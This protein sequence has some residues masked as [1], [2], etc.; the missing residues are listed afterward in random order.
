MLV[1]IKLLKLGFLTKSEPFFK[2]FVIEGTLMIF[3]CFVYFPTLPS[4]LQ[5]RDLFL[6]DRQLRQFRIQRKKK[7]EN[8]IFCRSLFPLPTFYKDSNQVHYNP[9][10]LIK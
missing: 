10:F 4:A 2:R 8:Q 3:E 6:S 1:R 9:E 7:T 5:S